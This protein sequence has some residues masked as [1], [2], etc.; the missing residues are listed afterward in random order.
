MPRKSTARVS[1]LQAA[2][3][4]QEGLTLDVAPLPTPVIPAG[5]F[6]ANDLATYMREQQRAERTQ[7]VPGSEYTQAELRAAY[8]LVCDPDNWKNPIDAW[9]HHSLIMIVQEAI[10][11]FAGCQVEV[12]GQAG[13]KLHVKAAGYYAAIGA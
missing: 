10:M 13:R 4:R 8:D 1:K 2:I 9:I 12:V 6:T 3:S 7:S 5:P 11:H